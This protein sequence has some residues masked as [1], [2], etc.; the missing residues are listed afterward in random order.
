MSRNISRLLCGSA[1]AVIT[2]CIFISQ[3][4]RRGKINETIHF[5][6]ATRNQFV[7]Y[8]RTNG[9]CSEKRLAWL[10]WMEG[11]CLRA[12]AYKLTAE[13]KIMVN[14]KGLDFAKGDI[15]CVD[16]S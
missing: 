6:R 3:R 2:G 8:R 15:V 11:E 9:G 10:F 14:L 13:A 12:L 16:V 1:V 7:L 4:L 5:D